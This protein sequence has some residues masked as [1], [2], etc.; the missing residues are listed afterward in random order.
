M[1]L[2]RLRLLVLW[3]WWCR[4]RMAGVLVMEKEKE[5]LMLGW[6][7]W[8]SV[9]LHHTH[10]AGRCI[11][12]AAADRPR[13][14]CV[15]APPPAAVPHPSAPSIAAAM[16]APPP[17]LPLRQVLHRPQARDRQPHLHQRR[18]TLAGPVQ[19]NEGERGGGLAEREGGE[20]ERGREG[21]RAIQGRRERGSCVWAA[22]R[23]LAAR[24]VVCITPSRCTPTQGTVALRVVYRR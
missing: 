3:W 19:Q 17:L 23:A 14:L 22:V 6:R 11:R 5:V 10:G 21:G 7:L 8:I 18:G 1:L 20:T 4:G 24:C 15:P 16:N 12:S 13:L 9:S 2:L